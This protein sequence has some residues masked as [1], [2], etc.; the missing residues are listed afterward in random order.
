MCIYDDIASGSNL[1]VHPTVIE[2]NTDPMV[3]NTSN[4][5]QEDCNCDQNDCV[6]RL[7]PDTNKIVF[8]CNVKT[9]PNNNIEV[10]QDPRAN[11]MNQLRYNDIITF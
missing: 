2:I 5:D 8:D 9:E 10:K 3:L 7:D 6:E 11:A 1:A 4:T